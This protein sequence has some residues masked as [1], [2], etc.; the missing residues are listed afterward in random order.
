MLHKTCGMPW[1]RKGLCFNTLKRREQEHQLRQSTQYSVHQ[2][3][4]T[5]LLME[6][7]STSARKIANTA[8]SDTRTPP[9]QSPKD[10]T[11]IGPTEKLGLQRGD[12]IMASLTP[13]GG[14]TGT[15]GE[16]EPNAVA[17]AELMACVATAE[18][19]EGNVVCITGHQI[20]KKRHQSRLAYSTSW[21]R[22][23]CRCGVGCPKRLPSV[24]EPSRF[25]GSEHV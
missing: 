2:N 21:S 1:T 3:A 5:C 17:R 18:S 15:I 22:E 23:Q 13:L 20:L 11:S 24:R 19:I 6:S 25:G 10:C 12:R 7:W 4:H 9:L 14:W 16:D 8:M